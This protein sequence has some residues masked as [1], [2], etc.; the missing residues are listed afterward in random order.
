MQFVQP[1]GS[2]T[3]EI[4]YVKAEFEKVGVYL[5]RGPGPLPR[6]LQ[7]NGTASISEVLRVC[8]VVV[9][10]EKEFRIRGGLMDGWGVSL[11]DCERVLG[12]NEELL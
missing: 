5:L 11:L 10:L 12:E 3:Y 4:F 2:E 8:L 9:C 6:S 7:R 1:N